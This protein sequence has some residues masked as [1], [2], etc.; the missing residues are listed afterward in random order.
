VASGI[1]YAPNLTFDRRGGMWVSSGAPFAPVG[2]GVWYVTLFGAGAVVRFFPGY[3]PRSV[4]I[5]SKRSSRW[6]SRR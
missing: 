1:P 2:D 4:R 6:C 3:G 5:A